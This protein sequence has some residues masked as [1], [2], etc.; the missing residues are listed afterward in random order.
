MNSRFIRP[1]S[2][3]SPVHVN[4]T[5]EQLRVVD[6]VGGGGWWAWWVVLSG[7]WVRDLVCG[8]WVM[9]GW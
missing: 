7:R 8:G 9:S 5:L 2:T 1:V 6:L 4:F 3:A